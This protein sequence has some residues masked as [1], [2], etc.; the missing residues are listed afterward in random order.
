MPEWLGYAN[1]ALN[2]LILPLL[3]VLWGMSGTIAE[4]KVHTAHC[5]EDTKILR[6][7]LSDVRSQVT[8]AAVAAAT[9]AATVVTALAEIRKPQ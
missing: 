3:A 8:S 7:E 6:T 1:L 5:A 9:A 2:L 4:L